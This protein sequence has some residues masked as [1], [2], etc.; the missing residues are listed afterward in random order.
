MCPYDVIGENKPLLNSFAT[1]NAL[2]TFLI[3]NVLDVY[4][5]L[6]IHTIYQEIHHGKGAASITG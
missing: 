1:T 2:S 6:H 5:H 4:I 3:K